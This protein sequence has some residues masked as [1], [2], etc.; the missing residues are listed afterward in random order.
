MTQLKVRQAI[1]KEI[2]DVNA[3]TWPSPAVSSSPRGGAEEEQGSPSRGAVE[4]PS[5][6]LRLHAR[7]HGRRPA[8]PVG[9]KHEERVRVRG[10]KGDKTIEAN[11]KHSKYPENVD[12]L[13]PGLLTQHQEKE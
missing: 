9:E 10:R 3:G 13:V 4:L 5:R 7:V 11:T 2:G 6:A 8:P 1:F 12:Q